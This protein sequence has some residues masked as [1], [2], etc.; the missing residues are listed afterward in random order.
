MG[1]KSLMFG[2]E[3]L[4]TFHLC[5]IVC[6]STVFEAATDIYASIVAAMKV[7]G[8]GLIDILVVVPALTS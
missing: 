2:I 3:L 1:S 8:E 6:G 7:V 5:F 4:A